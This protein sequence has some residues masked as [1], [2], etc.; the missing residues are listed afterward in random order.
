MGLANAERTLYYIRV[1]TEF[2]SQPEWK[3]VVP[4]FGII[5]EPLVGIIGMDVITSLCVFL[6]MER[7]SN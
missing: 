3:D 7:S 1:I 5:N 4:V 6:P 2:I